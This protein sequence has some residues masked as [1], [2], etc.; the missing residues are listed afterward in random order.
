[1]QRARSFPGT[2][3]HMCLQLIIRATSPLHRQAVA[4]GI[5]RG[6]AARRPVSAQLLQ[7]PDLLL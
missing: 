3:S 6:S 7:L 1:M 5:R 2:R 4:S